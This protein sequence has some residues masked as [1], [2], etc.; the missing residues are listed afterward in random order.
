MQADASMR[1]Y[2]GVCK[3]IQEYA[4]VYKSM[5]EYTGVYRSMQ[6]YARV[7]RAYCA[8]CFMALSTDSWLSTF[9]NN[10]LVSCQASPG[11]ASHGNH[12]H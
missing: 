2:T 4:E 12:M 10:F 5:Q 1:E 9:S 7:Y 11:E 6:E 3:S 8:V